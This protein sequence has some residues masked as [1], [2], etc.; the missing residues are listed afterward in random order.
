LHELDPALFTRIAD[1]FTT[2]Y[3]YRPET[4]EGMYAVRAKVVL[5]WDEF[6]TSATKWTF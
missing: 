6:P 4:G 2:R 3:H 1:S 5:A